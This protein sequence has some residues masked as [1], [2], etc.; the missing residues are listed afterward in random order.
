MLHDKPPEA[1]VVA[2]QPVRELVTSTAR[3]KVE[4]CRD[5]ELAER[6]VV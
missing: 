6:V 5:I 2:G 4:K 1:F 3:M